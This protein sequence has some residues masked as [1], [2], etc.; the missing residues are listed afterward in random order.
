[1][2]KHLISLLLFMR[3]VETYGQTAYIANYNGNYVHVVDVQS[4]T[5]VDSVYVGPNYN[6]VAVSPD[7]TRVY[8]SGI[9]SLKVINTSLNTVSNAISFSGI[10]GMRV[11]PDG[12]KVFIANGY[13]GLTVLNTSSMTYFGSITVGAN[14][15]GVACIGNNTVYVANNNDGNVSVVN[16]FTSFVTATIGVGNQIIWSSPVGICLNSNATRLYIACAG[17]VHV[18]NT[19]NNA[20]IASIPFSSNIYANHGLC[21]IAISPDD[22]KV[23]VTSRSNNSV[24]VIN[25]LNNTLVTTIPVGLW[26]NSISVTPDGTKVLV[27]NFSSNTVSVINAS[28]NTVISTI[29]GFRK[30][31]SFGNFIISSSISLSTPSNDDEK[32]L[33]ICPNPTNGQLNITYKNYSTLNGYILKI[34]N[35]TGQIVY[36]RAVNQPSVTID[37]NERIGTGIYFVHIIDGQG[38]TIAIKKIVVQ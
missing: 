9:D 22:S 4:S 32:Q 23:Y 16:I 25:T 13:S 18:I 6:N 38:K 5:I 14:P 15:Q 12:T 30:P 7:E 21:G 36:E 17:N 10:K 27:T 20:L 33:Y 37:L 26:P 1:M 8:V 11:S 34:A 31:S 3:I 2:K 35:L 19:S 24:G 28:T 29:S